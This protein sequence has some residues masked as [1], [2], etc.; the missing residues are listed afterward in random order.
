MIKEC[1]IFTLLQR[2]LETLFE[3]PKLLKSGKNLASS[4]GLKWGNWSKGFSVLPLEMMSSNV[5][6]SKSRVLNQT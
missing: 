2:K 5:P 6:N 3:S 4:C 1:M